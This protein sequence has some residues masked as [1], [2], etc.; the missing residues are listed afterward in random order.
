MSSTRNR[1]IDV[2]LAGLAA[3][4][5]TLVAYAWISPNERTSESGLAVLI[6][7][8]VGITIR[9]I[10]RAGTA[11][12]AQRR[13]IMGT[14]EQV[15]E[16]GVLVAEAEALRHAREELAAERAQFEAERTQFYATA[17]AETL[18][19]ISQKNQGHVKILVPKPDN[20][21]SIDGELC[22]SGTDGQTQRSDRFE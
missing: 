13:E 6:I 7:G 1:V 15:K 4:G 8:A 17:V 20:D 11:G 19:A 3:V 18:H 12:Q 16:G 5:L 21:N 9:T 14:I 2:G 10:T 22:R